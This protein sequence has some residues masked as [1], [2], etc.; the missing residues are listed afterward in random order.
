MTNQKPTK[1][2]AG[3]TRGLFFV[4]TGFCILY[5]AGWYFVSSQLSGVINKAMDDLRAKG[6]E[7]ACSGQSISGFPFRIGLFCDSLEIDEQKVGFSL[8]AGALRTTAVVYRPNLILAELDGPAN[9]IAPDMPPFVLRWKEAGVSIRPSTP[10]PE[11]L[12]LIIDAP[13]VQYRDLGGPPLGAAERAELHLRQREENLVDIALMINSIVALQS[14]AFSLNADLTWNDR[15]AFAAILQSGMIDALFGHDGIINGMTF[16]PVTGGTLAISGPIA[17]AQ[18]G[19]L[20]A[21][22]SVEIK[23]PEKLAGFV[24]KLGRSLGTDILPLMNG[25]NAAAM[26]G[27]N[28][29]IVVTIINNQARIGFIP[30]GTIPRF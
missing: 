28:A 21:T 13:A 11:R 14:D 2:Y 24:Q 7:I 1:S 29:P 20:N 18:D 30:L 17:F 16:A 6:T 26:M 3:Y 5:A 15:A 10:L 12:S 25:L 4:V 23:E 19:A 27:S 22:L 9:I 8:S